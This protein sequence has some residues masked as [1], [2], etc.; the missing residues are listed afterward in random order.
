MIRSPF[1]QLRASALA[2]VL[3]TAACDGDDADDADII[4]E[5]ATASA[6]G[7]QGERCTVSGTVFNDGETRCDVTIDFIG[8]GSDGIEI[9]IA[10]SVLRDL[11]GNTRSGYQAELVSRTG[12]AVRCQVI[13]EL[14]IEDVNADC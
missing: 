4:V 13:D 6:A 2:I 10:Q 7:G 14:E 1:G 11:E 9:A 12:A 3:V 8:L 5:S